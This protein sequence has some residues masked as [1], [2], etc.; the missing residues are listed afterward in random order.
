M[1][2]IEFPEQTVVIAKDQPEYRPLPAFQFANAPTGR[3][4]C[5][6]QLTLWE[7]IKLLFTGKLWHTVLTFHQPLQPQLI[8]L[9][10]PFTAEDVAATKSAIEKSMTHSKF[11]K[12]MLE[13]YGEA[14]RKK[15]EHFDALNY[16]PNDRRRGV[17]VSPEDFARCKEFGLLFI[18]GAR[19]VDAEHKSAV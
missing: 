9:K 3:I 10:K 19:I 5:C 1:K 11:Q 15:N 14:A 16:H 7:R 8:E 6:W 12:F 2:L 18:A 13:K 4:A 17:K